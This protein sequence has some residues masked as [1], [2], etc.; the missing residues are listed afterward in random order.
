MTIGISLDEVLRD[1]LSKLKTVYK[2]EFDK[3]PIEPINTFDINSHF[4]FETEDELNNFLYEE[5]S[6]ELFGHPNEKYKNVLI[7]LNS[8]VNKHKDEHNFIIISKEF[9]NS[10]PATL[11]FLSKTSC[12]LRDYK[13]VKSNKE[14]WD[15]C[16]IM[17][18]ANPE[19]LTSKPE[20][21]ITIKV[22]CDYNSDIKSDYEI[23]K[24][25]N[26]L[27]E[28]ILSNITNTKIISYTK[29]EE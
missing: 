27:E 15:Y 4:P 9:G 28:N 22:K 19:V 23:E 21:K 11:F 17:I 20:N 16:D 6:L 2:K 29:I 24:I 3:D 5:F 7:D 10:I 8:L 12:K 1:F 26:V 13:F 25:K 14:V 18:T